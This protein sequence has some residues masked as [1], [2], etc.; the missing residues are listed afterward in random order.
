MTLENHGIQADWAADTTLQK[1]ISGMTRTRKMID[2]MAHNIM[3]GI[4][5]RGVHTSLQLR[6]EGIIALQFHKTDVVTA[7]ADGSIKLDSGGYNVPR[8]Y[9]GSRPAASNT[10]KER[11]QRYLPA[12]VQL[13]QEKNLWWLSLPGALDDV[14]F[15]DG[16]V[17]KVDEGSSQVQYPGEESVDTRTSLLHFKKNKLANLRAIE[18]EVNNALHS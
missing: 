12:G 17:I 6:G 7:Y 18:R 4:E 9:Q 3:H 1:E 11:I 15:V 16:M 13:Y 8:I 2:Q 14:E 10:T 5:E